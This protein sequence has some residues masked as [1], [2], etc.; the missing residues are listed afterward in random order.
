MF[1][2]SSTVIPKT[3]T[4]PVFSDI[5]M[6]NVEGTSLGLGIQIKGLPEQKLL[7]LR[8]SNIHLQAKEAMICTDVSGLVMDQ[9]EVTKGL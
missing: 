6:E 7:N 8:L 1:Y 5:S 4:P 9:V 2:E 3:Q